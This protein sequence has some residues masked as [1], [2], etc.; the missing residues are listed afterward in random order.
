VPTSFQDDFRIHK[1][2][3]IALREDSGTFQI[4]TPELFDTILAR[5]PLSLRSNIFL[6]SY[7]TEPK[8]K[9]KLGIQNKKIQLANEITKQ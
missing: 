2:I 3:F 9:M 1:F 5:H 8:K 7:W 6:F 4:S